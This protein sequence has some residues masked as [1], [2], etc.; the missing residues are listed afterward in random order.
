M[1]KPICQQFFDRCSSFFNIV[2]KT[3]LTHM[4]SLV[5]DSSG[6]TKKKSQIKLTNMIWK[7]RINWRTLI[8]EPQ[9]DFESNQ[10]KS[11]TQ[12]LPYYKQKHLAEI[13][14]T[15]SQNI[16][17]FHVYFGSRWRIIFRLICTVK[18]IFSQ[19]N[20]HIRAKV[21]AECDFKQIQW[22]FKC[23]ALELLLLAS[24]QLL[25]YVIIYWKGKFALCWIY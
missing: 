24:Y 15:I 6:C 1:D 13:G 5:C 3:L 10:L 4:K 21:L 25:F 22:V 11:Q 20:A 12:Y 17:S 8:L 7:R 2:I 16:Y 23:G 14:T 19:L 18:N 9:T